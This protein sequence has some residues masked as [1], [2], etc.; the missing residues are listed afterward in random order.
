MLGAAL[1]AQLVNGPEP[2]LAGGLGGAAQGPPDLAER[3][4]LL[5]PQNDDPAVLLGQQ[6]QPGLDRPGLLAPDRLRT[7]RAGGGRRLAPLGGL[8]Q[9]LQGDL[10]ADPPLFRGQVL[11]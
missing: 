8:E 7:R 3:P 4:A 9:G 1:L 10:P 2:D 11:A 5:V 6:A